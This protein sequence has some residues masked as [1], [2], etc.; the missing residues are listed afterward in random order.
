MLHSDGCLLELLGSIRLGRQ[1]F[2]SV[3]RSSLFV[4]SV[5]DEGKKFYSIVALSGEIESH[6]TWGRRNKTVYGNKSGLVIIS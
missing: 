4:L 1:C 2:F 5:G 3:K 6:V